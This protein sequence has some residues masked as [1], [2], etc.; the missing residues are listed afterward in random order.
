MKLH[1][2]VLDVFCCL[3][4]VFMLFSQLQAAYLTESPEKTLPPIDLGTVDS[5]DKP[6]MTAREP[7]TISAKPGPGGVVYFIENESVD[8]DAIEKK[9]EQAKPGEVVLRIDGDVKHTV[10]LKLLEMCNRQG[11]RNISFAAKAA[12]TTSAHKEA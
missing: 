3:L 11:I 5:P 9:L 7:M 1:P 8:I 12:D 10:S 4:G 6:G 2:S